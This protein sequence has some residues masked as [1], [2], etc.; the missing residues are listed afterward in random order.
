[1]FL[2]KYE[3]RLGLW[4]QL[5]DSLETSDQPF[6]LLVKFWEDAPVVNI[7]ADPY[8]QETWP[9]PWEMIKENCYCDFVKLLAYC[10]S[11][12]LTTRF[13][14]SQFEIHI[15]Y[16]KQRSERCYLLLVDDIYLGYHE[17]EVID[18][19]LL[20]DDYILEKKYIMMPIH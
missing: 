5:R 8:D 2:K 4:R 12:Q 10:Y 19:K 16:N 14:Q 17:N 11:L 18:S 15:L 13:S 7:A 20:V 3:E 1:M 6:N 9:D